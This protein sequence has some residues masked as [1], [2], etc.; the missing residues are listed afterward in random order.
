MALEQELATYQRELP[1]LLSKQGKFV[2]I[3]GDEMAG[4][5]D[6]YQDALRAAYERYHL[7]SFLVKRIEAAEHAQLITRSLE[8][9]C[10]I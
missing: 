10:H 6:T 9:V 7:G 2:V 4:I 1:Q 8:G 3:R 5:W